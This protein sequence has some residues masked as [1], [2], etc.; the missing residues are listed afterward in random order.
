M[1]RLMSEVCALRSKRMLN[2]SPLEL[3]LL[4]ASVEGNRVRI[5]KTA[6]GEPIGYMAWMSLTPESIRYV[7]DR[8]A[9]P[10]YSYEWAE[11]RLM[12]VFDVVIAP[13]WSKV[14]L[15]QM[16]SYL[17]C[18]KLVSYYKRSCVRYIRRSSLKKYVNT[19]V[20]Y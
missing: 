5:F 18:E 6:G 17:S 7:R 14:V 11:G 8:R 3:M 10:P 12:M 13:G 20:V 1:S 19:K 16:A 2:T 9:L 15:D 4:S